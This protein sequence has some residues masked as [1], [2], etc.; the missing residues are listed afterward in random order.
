MKTDL[1]IHTQYSGDSDITF[2]NLV[3]RCTALGF[4]AIA[5]TDHGTA[6][7]ALRLSKEPTPF[8]VIVGEEIA[9]DEGEIIGLFLK[10]TIPNGLSP[11]ETI[12]QIRRQGGIVCIPH[13]FDH[14][15]SSALQNNTLDRIAKDIDIV[16]VFNARTIPAQ[17]LTLPGKFAESHNLLKGAGSDS[18]SVGEVGRAYITIP[19]FDGPDSF[20]KAMSQAEIH[21]QRPNPGIYIRSLVRRIKKMIN[22]LVSLPGRTKAKDT[23]A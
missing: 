19:D 14:Y 10:E 7:G 13:P 21:G 11:E 17:N 18:H 2:E 20:L 9:S 22:K 5:I 3:Q 6:E 4:G 1:H 15:R 12:K 8:K 16:E 23:G